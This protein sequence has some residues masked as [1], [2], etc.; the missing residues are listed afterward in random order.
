MYRRVICSLKTDFPETTEPR[1]FPVNTLINP[2]HSGSFN[3]F[4]ASSHHSESDPKTDYLSHASAD[5][6]GSQTITK[7]ERSFAAWASLAVDQTGI[8][9]SNFTLR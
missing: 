5:R 7:V 2:N 3:G 9:V 6:S 1:S 8:A 4:F